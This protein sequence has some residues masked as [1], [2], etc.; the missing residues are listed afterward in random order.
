MS[1]GLYLDIKNSFNAVNHRAI[2]FILEANGYGIP[3]EDINLFRR[4]YTGSFLVMVN[5]FGKSAV[6]I[7]WQGVAQ[8]TPPSPRVFNIT[9][10]PVHTIV[11]ACTQGCTLQESIGSSGFADDSPLHTD[12]PDAIPAL[13]IMVPGVA[14]YVEWAGNS[15]G[16]QDWS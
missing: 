13:A 15:C 8:G 14:G 4:M 1:V 11:R 6:C 7:L 16:Y 10:D 12:G 2:L 3:M 5:L 9:F